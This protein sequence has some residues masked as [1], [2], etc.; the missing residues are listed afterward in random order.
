VPRQSWL[1]QSAGIFCDELS[2]LGLEV[3]RE[4]VIEMLRERLSAVTTRMGMSE[5]SAR[6]YLTEEHLKEMARGLALTVAD[7]RP[8]VD[9]RH[10]PRTIPVSVET[11]GRV[12]Q[13]LAEA[14]RVRAHDDDEVG[15]DGGLDAI[16]VLTAMLRQS[17]I[18]AEVVLAPQAALTRA[19]RM[20][21]AA[22][23]IIG[24][25][26]ALH[27]GPPSEAEKLASASARTPSRFASWSAST[28]FHLAQRT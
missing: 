27:P 15:T 24:Q 18:S 5:Q 17:D 16:L 8:G 22:A 26:P 2:L 11:I 21:S 25:N 13:A 12:I 7:E 14:T 28:D 19:A 10:E 20:L 6:L 3:P 4:R 1:D 23:E 9:L